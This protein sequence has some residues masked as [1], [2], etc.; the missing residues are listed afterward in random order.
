MTDAYSAIELPPPFRL[1]VLETVPSTND[2]LHALA[3]S[4]APDALALVAEHQTTGRGRR[5]SPWFSHPEDSLTF[6]ILVRPPEP[7]ALWPRLALAAGL[8]VAEALESFGPTTT[9]KWPND[10]WMD[11]RKVAG[12]LVE[13]GSDFAIVGIGVNV[14]TSSFPP[15]IHD[16]AT[17]LRVATGQNHPRSAVLTAILERFAQ[18]QS[19]IDTPFPALL[20]A[21][22]PRCVLTGHRV[23]LT[24]ANRLQTGI[25]E[26]ISPSGELLLRTTSGLQSLIQA[27]E[28]RL[29]PNDDASRL[30]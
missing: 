18:R 16:I 7:R 13:A 29:I 27:D 21:V 23:S 28:I 6:S 14:N 8:A 3:Q 17:S 25:V 1:V 2:A 4:G 12:I 11:Q 15:E 24:T 5:G 22:R 9:I 19:Q 10:V 20:A 26:G 30:T